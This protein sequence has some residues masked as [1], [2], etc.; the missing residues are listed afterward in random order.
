MNILQRIFAD[1]FEE[2]VYTLHPRDSVIENVDKMINCGD[3]SF[4]GAMYGCPHCGNLKFVPFRCHSKFCPSCGAK[5]SNDRSTAMSFKLIQCTHRHLVFTIDESLRRFFLEDRTLLNCLF[6]A[7]SD[8]IKEYFF[9]LNKSKNFVP[10][11]ICVLHTF[12]RPLGWNPHIH[13]LLTEGGFSDDGVWR[14]VTYFN[15]S[16]LRKSFQTVLLNKLEKRI[17]PSF[18]KMKAAVYHRDRNGFYVYAKPNLCDPKSIIKYVSRYLGRPVIALSRIDSYDGEMVTFHYNKHEDNSFVK[19][20]LPAIDFIKLLILHIPEKNFKMTRYYGLYARHREIDN[21]LHKAVPKSKHRILLD[22]NTWRKLFLLTMGYDPLQC[23]NCRH[24]MV[25]L[26][27]YHK[28]ERVPLDELY[29]RTRIRH[30]L[31]PRS[32]SA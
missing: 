25:F 31:Y 7:V 21:Q 18:K 14:K 2:I 9:S 20:T 3:H 24:E 23:P 26:E 29:K 1:H 4:G 19:K 22:F 30:G 32:R 13:C 12:G 5:Y 11:F 8:V 16:Y 15:Y 6:E 27:L 10:G 17:G 28:H